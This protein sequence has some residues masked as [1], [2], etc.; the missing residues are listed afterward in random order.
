MLRLE[1]VH[2]RYGNIEALKGVSLD[3]EQGEI[4]TI[5]GANG[6]GKST[7]L[8]TICGSP[9]ASEGRVL[10]EGRDITRLPTY[11]IVNLGISQSPEEIRAK[12]A[13]AVT[14][15]NTIATKRS[16]IGE[17]PRRT[18]SAQPHAIS[19]A[20]KTHP[21]SPIVCSKLSASD[22]PLTPIQFCTGFEV[23]VPPEGSVRL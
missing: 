22:A 12:A 21:P 14:A 5:I 10:Y 6:A 3:V 11:D 15:P 16:H 20:P 4:V 8:M 9:K 17:S 1:N 19:A 7:L 23:A 13:A 2:T 18:R